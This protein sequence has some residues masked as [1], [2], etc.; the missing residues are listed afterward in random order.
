[1][2]M[3]S[4]RMKHAQA[5]D[6]RDLPRRRSDSLVR[7]RSRRNY[8]RLQALSPKLIILNHFLF[9]SSCVAIGAVSGFLGGLLGIGGGVVLNGRIHRGAHFCAGEIGPVGASTHLLGY[10][11]AFG[12][13]RPVE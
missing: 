11:S 9:F 12:V 10:T 7:C 5:P 13:F 4:C 1:M 3:S 2:S 6:R 8:S